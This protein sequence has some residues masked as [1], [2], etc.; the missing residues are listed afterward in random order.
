MCVAIGSA[1]PPLDPHVC[2]S[3]PVL[4]RRMT[5]MPDDPFKTLSSPIT[6]LAKAEQEQQKT[7]Q[8]A[9][10]LTDKAATFLG[11]VFG[12]A[13]DEFGLALGERTRFW[14]F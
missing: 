13:A 3:M 10:G 9:I 11:R 14:Q 4:F 8:A 2:G 12:H 1:F 7:I 5:P 6:E